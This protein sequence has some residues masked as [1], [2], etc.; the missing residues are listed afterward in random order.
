MNEVSVVPRATFPS[1]YILG[2]S[3]RNF[4]NQ[5]SSSELQCPEF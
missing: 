1:S 4:A 3:T 5:G 2:D